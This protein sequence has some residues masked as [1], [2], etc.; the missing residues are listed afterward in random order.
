MNNMPNYLSGFR[1]EWEKDPKQANLAW[2]EQARF[3]LFIHYGLYSQLADGEWVQFRQRIPV[4]EYEKLADTFD[5][6]GFDADFITDLALEAEMAYVNLVSCH[7]DSFA[8]WGSK[9][10]PFNSVNAPAGRDLVSEL[11]EQCANKG[12]GFFTYYTYHQNWRHPYFLSRDYYP[13]ARP[14]YSEP[15]PRYKFSKPGDFQRYVDYAHACIEELLVNCGPLAGMWLDLIMGYY[16]VPDMMPVEETYELIRGLQAHTLISFKQGATGTEDFATPERHFHSLEE[17]AREQYGEKSAEVA[18]SVWEKNKSKHNEICATLQRNKWGYA[19]G[20]RHFDAGDVR[21]LL[22][23]ALSHN[24]NL[25]LNTGPL[26][27]GSIPDEDVATLREVG[28]TIRNDGWPG[29]DEA[30][31]PGEEGN[32]A[33]GASAQ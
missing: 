4:S 9:A 28:K 30:R 11:S 29:P 19:K 8:L 13:S 14:D 16:A 12:L 7:H 32:T 1:S 24:S 15:E 27:D 22:A 20:E 6:G 17:R 10:E 25:L 23:H 21:G 26:P 2:W 18:R 3:G 5:P 33:G 31:I